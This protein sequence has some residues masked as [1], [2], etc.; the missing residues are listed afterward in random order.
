MENKHISEKVNRTKINSLKKII[1][2]QTSD[3]IFQEER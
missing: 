1:K 3:K 2:W